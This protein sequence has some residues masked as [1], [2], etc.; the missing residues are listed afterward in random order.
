MPVPAYLVLC[1]DQVGGEQWFG[2]MAAFSV[3]FCIL[4]L[5]SSFDLLP[6]SWKK[7]GAPIV[8]VESFIHH[9]SEGAAPCEHFRWPQGWVAPASPSAL[10][11]S[12]KQM[13]FV[14][15]G[16]SSPLCTLAS[17]YFWIRSNEPWLYTNKERLVGLLS[18]NALLS[19]F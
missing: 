17:F 4:V 6:A 18:G 11:R 13:C 3:D 5:H 8:L 10:S 14:G 15:L 12:S 16:S 7:T 19:I 9:P 1:K 2:V